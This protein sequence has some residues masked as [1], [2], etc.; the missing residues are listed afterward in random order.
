MEGALW[1]DAA[2]EHDVRL[3]AVTR[4]GFAES[5]PLPGRTLLDWP[6]DVI[7]LA[8]HLGVERFG[9]MGISGGGPYVLACVKEIPKERLVAG[10]LICSVYPAT[11][12]LSGMG[13][14]GRICSMSLPGSLGW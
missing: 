11:L 12:G 3:I 5:S 4:P 14:S 10:G 1:H 8:D 2:L 6:K 13:M 7:A 9:A